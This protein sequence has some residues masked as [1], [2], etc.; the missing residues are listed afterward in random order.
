MD[1]KVIQI[2]QILKASPE[3]MTAQELADQIGTSKQT[4]FNN[5]KIAIREG[6]AEDTGLK[7]NKANLFAAPNSLNQYT[8]IWGDQR[9]PL[10]TLFSDWGRGSWPKDLITRIFAKMVVK[11]YSVAISYAED[12]GDEEKPFTDKIIELKEMRAALG[13]FAER[14][15]ALAK[16]SR[17]LYNDEDLWHPKEIVNKLIINDGTTTPRE[18][19]SILDS[20][21]SDD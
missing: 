3:P 21:Q 11:L 10:K 7:R 16:A 12:N 1:I 17:M 6:Y 14:L 8:V 15:E 5:M 9:L 2:G 20:N 13:K 4:I 19:R 18:I